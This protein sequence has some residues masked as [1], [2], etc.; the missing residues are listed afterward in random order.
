MQIQADKS[1]RVCYF[2]T[3][4]ANYSRNQIM[5]A[6]LRAAGV[7]VVECHETLWHGVEDRVKAVSGG[8]KHPRFWWRVVRTYGRL[9][10]KY[11]LVDDYDIMVVGYPGQFDVYLA[12]WLTRRRRKPLVLDVFM[13]LYLIAS[14]R[15][16]TSKHPFT[17]RLLFWVEK[18]AYR[19]PDLLIQDTQ[20]YVQWFQQV[21]GLD[22][23]RFRLVPTGADDRVW[24]PA[25][26]SNKERADFKLVYYGTF[27]PN[28]GV[29]H[30]IEAANILKEE[31]D[32]TFELIGEGP[33]KARTEMLAREYGLTNVTFLGWMDQRDLIERV[34]A[35]DV[36]LGVFGT[37]P[38]STMTIQNKIYEGLAMAKC[39]VT[40][41]SAAARQAL[42]H[43]Q[44]VWFC[45][46]ANPA[47]LAEAI[48]TLRKNADLRER[49]GRNGYEL[50]TTH[51]SLSALG[52]QY[53]Q[54]LQS[55]K[56]NP[57]VRF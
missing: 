5:I 27:I 57:R 53:R 47:S 9:L 42:T 54:H 16:L 14:E 24:R 40:G 51:Y 1:L 3:F 34:I 35:A 52:R 8:W 7:Q 56:V 39:V 55:L 28:H 18:L 2:G 21:F 46:R 43:G 15:G 41:D 19:L 29:E 4:R 26:R 12:R 20:E 36:C 22:P 13:S 49:L 11:R 33:E 38:Q 50:F 45:E 6:G 31:T 23:G 44:H 25:G 17:A 10:R 32:I 30:I 48:L 37:T